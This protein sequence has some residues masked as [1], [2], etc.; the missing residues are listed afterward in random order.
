LVDLYLN[1]ISSGPPF[2]LAAEHRPLVQRKALSIDGQ[3]DSTSTAAQQHVQAYQANEDEGD[4]KEYGKDGRYGTPAFPIN[5]A[6]QRLRQKEA[7]EAQN[8]Q[9]PAQAPNEEKTAHASDQTWSGQYD[10]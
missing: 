2:L 4:Q 8:K 1:Q 6:G 3:H 5:F 10:F 7:Q 9:I